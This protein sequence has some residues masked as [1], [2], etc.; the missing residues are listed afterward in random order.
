MAIDIYTENNFLVFYYESEYPEG[1]NV[2]WVLNNLEENE[3]CTIAKSFH[4]KKIDLL[5]YDKENFSFVRFNIANRI[6]YN[7]IKYYQVK[8]H[9]LNIKFDLLF[10]ESCNIS[11]NYFFYCS[12]AFYFQNN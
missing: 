12:K 10:E 2:E 9:I 1:N 11:I 6:E 5:D 3:S 7:N 8:K 4:F